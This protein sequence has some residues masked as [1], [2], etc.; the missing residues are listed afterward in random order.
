MAKQD[1]FLGSI[2]VLDTITGLFEGSAIVAE[3]L[4]HSA[5]TLGNHVFPDEN[6]LELS[7]V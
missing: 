5:L 7:P 6:Y 1:R 4:E 2:I 3:F